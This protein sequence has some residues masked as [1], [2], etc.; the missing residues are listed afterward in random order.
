MLAEKDVS[1]APTDSRILI[2]DS[3]VALTWGRISGEC[4]QRGIMI[5]AVDGLI[6][7][8]ALVHDLTVITE[9]IKDFIETGARLFNP[10]LDGLK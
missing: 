6:A 1:D 4:K 3:E 9:N 2:V 8:I 10:W 7:A 5:P